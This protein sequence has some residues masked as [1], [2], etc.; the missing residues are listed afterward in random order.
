MFS[1]VPPIKKLNAPLYTPSLHFL[2]YYGSPLK[3][4]FFYNG[5]MSYVNDQHQDGT[6]K[7]TQTGLVQITRQKT[8]VSPENE[9]HQYSP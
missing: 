8:L 9:T 6:E 3:S 5:I 4:F 7:I 2:E 1:F